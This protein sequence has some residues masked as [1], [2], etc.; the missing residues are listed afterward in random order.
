MSVLWRCCYFP[1]CILII[2]KPLYTTI[3]NKKVLKACFNFI[4]SWA[5]LN[6]I[7]CNFHLWHISH[8][9]RVGE[10]FLFLFW[11]NSPAFWMSIF[12]FLSRSFT[13]PMDDFEV[14]GLIDICDARMHHIS[15][16]FCLFI[17][18]AF[19]DSMLCGFCFLFSLLHLSLIIY[20]CGISVCRN[21]APCRMPRNYTLL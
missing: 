4:S 19:S 21:A 15:F 6:K 1:L 11:P 8:Y 7:K 12:V 3:K 13:E 5:H 20:K 17:V 10:T 16:S 14:H 2:A 9:F 18:Y